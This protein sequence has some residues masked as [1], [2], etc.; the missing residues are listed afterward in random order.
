VETAEQ[1]LS[2]LGRYLVPLLGRGPHG[3]SVAHAYP[4]DTSF[5]LELENRLLDLCDSLDTFEREADGCGKHSARVM[6]PI[7]FAERRL[8]GERNGYSGRSGQL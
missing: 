3:L 7:A 1:G 4:R 2:A 5:R 8:P 6:I